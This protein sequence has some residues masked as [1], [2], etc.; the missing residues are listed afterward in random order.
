MSIKPVIYSTQEDSGFLGELSQRIKNGNPENQAGLL[1]SYPTVYI[2]FWPGR[3]V[4]YIDKKG[5]SKSFQKYNVYVGESNNVIART[6]QHYESGEY[7]GTWQYILTHSKEIPQIIIVGHKYFNK[8][9]TLDMENRLIEYMMASE[10]SVE[11]L[12]N[13]RGNPQNEYYPVEEF[14]EVFHSVWRGLRRIKPDLFLSESSIQHSAL[15][16]A[17]PLKKLTDEQIEAKETIIAKIYDAMESGL[18]GQLVFVQGEAGTGKTVLNSSIFYEILTNGED[19]FGREIDCHILVNHSQ[20]ITVYEQIAKRL[21]LGD[22]IVHKPTQFINKFSSERKVDVA[23]VDEA[24]LLLTRGNQGYSGHNQL[25]DIIKRSRVTV[26]MFDEYQV[27]NNE[28]YWEPELL[29]KFKSIARRQHSY[30]GL[31]RQ[32]RM[33]CSPSTQKWLDDFVL[34]NRL[35]EFP[36]DDKYEVKSFDSPQ[37]LYEAICE[38]ASKEETRLSRLVATYDWEYNGVHRP[39]NK[40]FWDVEIGDWN[41]PWNYETRSELTSKELRQ[42]KDLAWAEQPHTINE[43]GSTYTIQG[44]DLS[45]VGVILGPSV[46]YRNGDIIFDPSES[47]NTRATSRRTLSDGSKQSFGKIFIR[48]EVKVLLSRGVKGLYIYACDDNLREALKTIAKI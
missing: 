18:D 15:Y 36:K 25:E 42:I 46:K 37:A 17:S 35:C 1:L 27:L 28:E 10:H 20:Q 48:N 3:L 16:K 8:S 24:H 21:G 38:K 7:P 29:E 23:F 47:Y 45:Y 4:Q 31:T 12:H 32:L 39:E 5:E 41:M 30:V 19:L 33:Q 26:V 13:G 40:A 43:V 44:F 2:H 6:K 34:I 22:D 9:F 11:T 14:E